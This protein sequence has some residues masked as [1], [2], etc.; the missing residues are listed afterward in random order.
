MRG[1]RDRW[2]MDG[3][4]C[5][6]AVHGSSVVVVVNASGQGQQE[7]LRTHAASANCENDGTFSRNRMCGEPA[8]TLHALPADTF[9][10]GP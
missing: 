2:M 3:G 5:C 7:K 1:R 8:A 4:G 9:Q 10:E 6:M